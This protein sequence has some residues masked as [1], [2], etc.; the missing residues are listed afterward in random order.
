MPMRTEHGRKGCCLG[1]ASWAPSFS[2]TGEKPEM[3]G[4]SFPRPMKLSLC[5]TSVNPF[6]KVHRIKPRATGMLDQLSTDKTASPSMEQP[7]MWCSDTSMGS[8]WSHEETQGLMG[9]SIPNLSLGSSQSPGI[10]GF[11]SCYHCRGAN[12]NTRKLSP[13]R[14]EH[15]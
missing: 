10:C 5:F 15:Y 6:F 8:F 4:C 2:T 11:V 14:P 13:L 7:L 9:L 12:V 1:M 3:V